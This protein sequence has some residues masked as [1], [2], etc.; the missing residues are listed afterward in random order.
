MTAIV[1]YFTFSQARV[2]V[3]ARGRQRRL[4]PGRRPARGQNC[5]GME[6]YRTK[7]TGRGGR[8]SRSVAEAQAR[9]E[10]QWAKAR[11]YAAVQRPLPARREPADLTEL[12]VIVDTVED[13]LNRFRVSP[14]RWGRTEA[15]ISQRSILTAVA[16]LSLQTGKRTVAASIRDLALMV[17]LSR[18]TARRA[19]GALAADGFLVCV[20][21]SEGGNA[22]E[23]GLIP[24]FSTA[25]RTVAS[26]PL[27]N[28]RP[29]L[30]SSFF[31]R[32]WW[33]RWN[34]S[35]L[36]AVTTSSPVLASVTSLARSTPSWPS[37]LPSRSMWPLVCSGSVPGIPPRSSAAFVSTV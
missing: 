22:A 27:D 28:P 2:H 3:P 37:T 6:H 25:P 34:A 13:L 15:A 18:D 26:Q 32:C 33:R 17:G 30:N 23:W 36:T 9:L 31:E 24:K 12:G 14:G 10:R 19:L 16:Y 5:P 7:N 35:S 11:E 29:P 20:T 1:G 21:L 4:E 8:R